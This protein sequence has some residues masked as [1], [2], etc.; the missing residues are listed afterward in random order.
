MSNEIIDLTLPSS[1]ILVDGESDRSSHSNNQRPADTSADKKRRKKKKRKVKASTS[2]EDGEVPADDGPGLA[3]PR[4]DGASLFFIDL[5]PARLSGSVETKAGES[6]KSIDARQAFEGSSSIT[7]KHDAT[8]LLLPGHVTVLNGGDEIPVEIITRPEDESDDDSYIQYLDYDDDRKAPGMVR[9]FEEGREDTKQKRVVC[10][11]CGKEGDHKTWEC[12]VQICL[13]CGAR[14]EHSTRG[15]PISKT[16][17]NCGMKGHINK[18]CPQRFSRR[19]A[20]MSSYDDCDRCGSARHRTNECPTLW[21]MYQYVSDAERD[22]ILHGREEKSA[23][24]LGD[25]GEGY[26]A[27]DE[28]CYNCGN[29]GHLG[30]DCR[31]PPTPPERPNEPSA[32]GSYNIMSGPFYDANFPASK[33]KARPPRDWESGDTLGDGWGFNA[34][35]NVGRQGRR[36]DRA[37]MEQTAKNQDAR[38]DPDDWFSNS[39]NVKNRGWGVLETGTSSSTPPSSGVHHGVP[40]IG[41]VANDTSEIGE[42]AH[43]SISLYVGLRNG[44]TDIRMVLIEGGQG[45]TAL[46]HVKSDETS[47]GRVT[48]A[49]MHKLQASYVIGG[50]TLEFYYRHYPFLLSILDSVQPSS[51]TV[52]ACHLYLW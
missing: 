8:K 50:G 3:E 23:L 39:R 16:C 52:Q 24:S 1:P 26:I 40:T 44:T 36:K 31:D 30:D 34:P 20:Q 42:I 15:C 29:P 41:I 10:K 37:R 5:A 13:T 51:T 18:T 22:A 9:Y 47:I 43:L 19:G 11:N 6:S 28:W 48:R 27:T 32:F 33:G 7:T 2:L 46:D 49:D 21:R 38:E 12:P 25:G 14:D 45:G 4:D 17:F 35:M